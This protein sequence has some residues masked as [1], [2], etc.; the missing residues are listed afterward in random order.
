MTS[1]LHTDFFR[2]AEQA[3]DRCALVQ[4]DGHTCTYG[5]LAFTARHI[6]NFI[7]SVSQGIGSGYIGVAAPVGYTGI[8]AVLGILKSGNAYVP[9]DY[10]SPEERIEQVV[11][12]AELEIV[13][14]DAGLYEQ[15]RHLAKLSQLKCLVVM[16]GRVV[17]DNPKV[18]SW[19]RVL[20][21]PKTSTPPRTPLYDDPAYVLH[22]SGST[23]TPKG[24]ILSHRNACTFVNW[25]AKAFHPEAQDRI[26]SRAPL[27]FDLSVWD[28]FNTFKAGATLICFDWLRDRSL[29]QRHSDYVALMIREKVNYLYTTPS[30]FIALINHGGLLEKSYALSLKTIMY[31]GEPFPVSYLKR[32]RLALPQLRI[33]NIY[34]PTETNII[35]CHWVRNGDLVRQVI[36]IGRE[37][38][39]TEI[40]VVND[41]EDRV[42]DPGEKGEIWCRGGTV[43]SGYLHNPEKTAKSR[44]QSPFHS[45]PAMFWKTGDYGYRDQQGLLYY[46]GRKDHQIKIRG[47]RVELGEIES[48]VY[49]RPEVNQCAVAFLRG[50]E[51]YGTLICFFSARQNQDVSPEVL[52]TYLKQKLPSPMVPHKYVRQARLPET[53]TGKIDRVTL[54][55][56]FQAA[57]GGQAH[58][59]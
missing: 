36:P 48:A 53:S 15:F 9:L 44:I 50:S 23:G 17:S 25:M 18:V 4:E 22:T 7:Q 41:Q 57:V 33:A 34:G 54:L 2:V 13:L 49:S 47:L 29:Y 55:R 30:T 40:L 35:T 5:D 3:A 43:T 19:E 59:G 8:A 32:I 16:G 21:C 56:Y 27:I 12:N 20:G 6:A 28:M 38:D 26:I 42:C 45:Y 31:A 10:Y 46:C 39:D 24:I 52:Q 11:R 14:V 51:G 1:L 58:G 37:V